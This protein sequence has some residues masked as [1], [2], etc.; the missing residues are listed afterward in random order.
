M[1]PPNVVPCQACAAPIMF[2]P[3]ATGKR[4]PLNA[5]PAPTGNMVIRDGVA[6]VARADEVV[7]NVPR[8]LSHFV[9]CPD[10]AKFRRPR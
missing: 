9:T 6:G 7:S 10:A 8:Y 5:A 4:I 3:T 2:L 1:I